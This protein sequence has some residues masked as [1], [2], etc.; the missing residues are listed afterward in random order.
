MY[1][2]MA[3][4]GAFEDFYADAAMAAVTCAQACTNNVPCA[5]YQWDASGTAGHLSNGVTSENLGGRKQ[6][7][8]R[9]QSI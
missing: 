5:S 3:D 8:K 4:Q 9:T 7:I 6:C 1:S 2:R